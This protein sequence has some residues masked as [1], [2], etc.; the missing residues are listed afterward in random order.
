MLGGGGVG[1]A[2]KAAI[3]L[4]ELFKDDNAISPY[5]AVLKR[6]SATLSWYKSDGKKAGRMPGFDPVYDILLNAERRAEQ[7][8]YDD[9]VSRTYRALEMYAQ[10]CLRSN[11]PSLSSDDIDVAKL[12]QDIQGLYEEK[13]NIKGRVQLPLAGSYEL[14]DRIGHPVR[15]VWGKQKNKILNVLEKRNCSFLAHGMNPIG[16]EDFFNF[17]EGAQS[18]I[19]NCDSVMNNQRGLKNALQLPRKI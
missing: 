11:D 7:G 14:L 10:F 13:R 2:P 8:N 5:N 17:Y 12:P 9:A 6:I 4:V 15:A 3:P 19:K 1:K 18:F 16:K